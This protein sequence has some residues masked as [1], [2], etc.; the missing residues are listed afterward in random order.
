MCQYIAPLTRTD[1]VDAK[2]IGII[3]RAFE[4]AG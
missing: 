2:L 1:E 3:Q 4:A